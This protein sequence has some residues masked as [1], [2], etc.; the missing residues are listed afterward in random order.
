MIKSNSLH[1]AKEVT[2]IQKRV[3]IKSKSVQKTMMT[4][5][6]KNKVKIKS[7]SIKNAREVTWMQKRVKKKYDSIKK[8]MLDTCLQKKRVKVK[9]SILQNTMKPGCSPACR[10]KGWQLRRNFAGSFFV[11]LMTRLAS[12]ARFS[13]SISISDVATAHIF[14][15]DF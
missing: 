4:T 11:A 14:F 12:M 7:N 3:R 15:L 5:C 9:F 1:N 13:P 2:F 8:A 10:G 6:M